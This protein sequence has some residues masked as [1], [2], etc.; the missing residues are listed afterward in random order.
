MILRR[1]LIVLFAAVLA[2]GCGGS[3]GNSK[4]RVAGCVDKYA[5]ATKADCQ[6]W[7]DAGELQD[8]GTHKGHENMS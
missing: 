4:D 7:E 2:S 5:D 1:S 6:E 3:D 8:D